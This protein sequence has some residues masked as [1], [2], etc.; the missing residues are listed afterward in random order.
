MNKNADGSKDESYFLTSL[1]ANE[2]NYDLNDD[3]LSIVMSDDMFGTSWQTPTRVIYID[4]DNTVY[5]YLPFDVIIKED[6]IK[7]I[8]FSIIEGDSLDF[9]RVSSLELITSD[10]SKIQADKDIHLRYK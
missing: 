3:K 4:D 10:L 2:K 9:C 7:N 5:S 6:N 8:K 1:Y